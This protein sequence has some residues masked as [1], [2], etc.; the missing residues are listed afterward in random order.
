LD[1]RSPFLRVKFRNTT[2]LN[3]EEKIE[4]IEATDPT[5]EEVASEAASEAA[6]E[7]TEVASEEAEVDLREEDTM[8]KEDPTEVAKIEMNNP[9][10][11][12]IM[13]I[14]KIGPEEEV[15]SE[16]VIEDQE[17]NMTIDK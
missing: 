5:E 8:V 4:V 7:E 16:E 14:E 6:S 9:G 3:T 17:L 2:K 12:E 1:I 11:E 15:V 10:K 13:V